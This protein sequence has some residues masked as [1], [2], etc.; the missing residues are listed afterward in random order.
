[1]VTPVEASRK[2]P[3]EARLLM[4]PEWICLEVFRHLKPSGGRR[5]G[6]IKEVAV[7]ALLEGVAPPIKTG[8]P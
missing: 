5:A 3:S 1:M 8:F 2:S 7:A 6:E 4:W